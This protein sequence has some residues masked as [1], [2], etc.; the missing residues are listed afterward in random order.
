MFFY[1]FPQFFGCLQQDTLPTGICEQ[2]VEIFLIE[3]SQ[4]IMLHNEMKMNPL[5]GFQSNKKNEA[6]MYDTK[7]YR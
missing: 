2:Y 6:K 4:R 3:W 7:Y 1:T 5:S